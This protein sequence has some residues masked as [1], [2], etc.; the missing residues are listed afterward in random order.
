M[1]SESEIISEIEMIVGTYSSWTIG[2]T[3]DPKR[4]KQEL[5]NPILWHD[6]DAD[7]ESSAKNIEEHFIE[8]GMKGSTG[9]GTSP[10][11]VYVF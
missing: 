5:G 1:A 11:Y 8:K 6:W 10:H 2:I 4:K 3:D 7:S 9:D